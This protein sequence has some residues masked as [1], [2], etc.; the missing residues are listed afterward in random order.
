MWPYPWPSRWVP[1]YLLAAAQRQILG[2]TTRSQEA[3]G[4]ANVAAGAAYASTAAI[5]VVG[6]ALAPAAAA[7]ALAATLAFVPGASAMGGFDIPQGLNPITQLHQNEMVLP[8]HLADP[9]RDMAARGG[10][11]GGDV[12]L[13]VHAIDS[14][15]ARRFLL[16]NHGA[17]ADSI[18]RAHRNAR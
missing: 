12:H 2:A 9:I 17:V 5:P 14:R 15:D 7:S 6:P 18:R 1:Q 3:V 4:N 10:D 11:G 13:H 8:A 16:D